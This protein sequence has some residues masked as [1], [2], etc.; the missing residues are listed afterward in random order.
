MDYDLKQLLYKLGAPEALDKDQVRWHYIDASDLEVGG[1]ADIRIEANGRLLTVQLKHTKKN[2]EDDCGTF[3]TKR[4]ESFFLQARRLGDSQ[5]F[6]VTDISFDGNDYSSDNTAMIELGCSIFHARAVE[7]NS[8]MV[9]QKFNLATDK[10][11]S[12][13]SAERLR[14]KLKMMR[15]MSQPKPEMWGIVV[16]FHPR[17][18]APIQRI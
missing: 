11:F 4:E 3:H 5:L 1:Y 2:C 17:K 18:G 12:N 14:D 15:E 8:L 9:E 13:S 16:P 10:D 7:I 6:R